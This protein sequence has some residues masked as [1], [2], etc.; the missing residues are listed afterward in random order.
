MD[1]PK[2]QLMKSIES[3]LIKKWKSRPFYVICDE[4]AMAAALNQIC[5]EKSEQVSVRVECHGQ[6]TRGQTVIDWNDKTGKLKNVRVVTKM[7]RD[8]VKLLLRR[9]YGCKEPIVSELK[10]GKTEWKF[11]R[12]FLA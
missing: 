6:L 1:D 7:N 12:T 9:T 3:K 11:K 2:A 4:L 5:M 10:P 8:L